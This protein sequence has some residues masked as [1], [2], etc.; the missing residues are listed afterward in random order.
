[1]QLDHKQKNKNREVGKKIKIT[2]CFRDLAE[3]HY[4]YKCWD[5]II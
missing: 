1:M 5:N 3:I 4:K 2:R